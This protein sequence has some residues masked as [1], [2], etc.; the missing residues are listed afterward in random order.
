VRKSR[1]RLSAWLACVVVGGAVVL[2]MSYRSSPPAF[3]Q[4]DDSIVTNPNVFLPRARVDDDVLSSLRRARAAEI[5]AAALQRAGEEEAAMD[6]WRDAFGR[7]EHLRRDHLRPDLGHNEE[8]LV[9]ADWADAS[10]AVQAEVFAESWQPLADYINS[11]LRTG[12]WPRTFR[13]RLAQRQR[14]PGAEMLELAL[15][16][17]DEDALR[18][19][20]RFYQFSDSGRRAL[21]LLAQRSLERGDAIMA[22]RWLEELRGAWPEH[23]ERTPSLHVL[24]VR[25]CRDADMDYRLGRMLRQLE[26]RGL[27]G[28]VDV[29]GRE[30][31]SGE[32]VEQ[33]ARQE[34]PHAR[35]ELQAGGWR[36][37]QGRFDRNG[38][39]P[40]VTRIGAMVDLNPG[41]DEVAGR[42]ITD[43]VSSVD[44]QR[45]PWAR[46]TRT[47]T[48]M[49]FPVT[50]ESGVYVP[51]LDTTDPTANKLYWFRHGREVNPLQLEIPRHRRYSKRESDSRHGGGWFHHTETPRD[52]FSVHG[53]SIGTL[54]YELDGREADALFAVVGPG[55]PSAERPSDPSGNQIQG[56]NL[57]DDASV[58]MTLPNERVES[59]EEYNSFLRHVVF[60]GAPL[61]RGNRLY[62]AGVMTE[63]NSF[64]TWLFCFDVTPK[65]DS[66]AGG[67]KLMWRAH[68]GSNSFPQ[69][70]RGWGRVTN[71]EPPEVSSPA[72]SGGMVFVTSHAGFTAG[73]EAESGEVAW[74]SRYGR[75]DRQLGWFNNAPVV[76]AGLVV[77]APYD[78]DLSLVLDTV[79]GT[80]WMEY[81]IRRMGFSGE[82]EHVLGAVDG[83]LI[84]Q[85]RTRLHCIG[86]PRFRPG[87]V[88]HTDYGDLVYQSTEFSSPPG[89][90]GVI[91]G[92]RILIPY[93]SSI[94]IYDVRTGKLLSTARLDGLHVD[95]LP[96][97]LTVFSRGPAYEDEFGQTRYGPVTVTD[98]ETGNQYNVEHLRNGETFTFPGTDR[99]AVVEKE[100]FLVHTTARWMH[101]FKVDDSKD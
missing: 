25:A 90:R 35:R 74:V 1:S 29:G 8:L 19:C 18:R 40:P 100:T 17:D 44:A 2:A 97:T 101:M 80:L 69:Q 22:V 91:A 27:S 96:A 67:G 6:R 49:I 68:L 82:Y 75:T 37:L 95:N 78:H 3:A 65:G 24:Y 55:A 15:R 81:P 26:R 28:T 7:Y 87:G 23:F 51:K 36:T 38:V 30:Y 16:N 63:R 47:P 88:R 89:G 61:I 73:V 56:W 58:L 54:R 21:E 98:P 48:P 4:S 83:H 86:L 50:H 60:R 57:S 64:E 39:A 77:T 43:K 45:D 71:V 66:A 70:G 9:R 52:T 20:A 84:I 13:D 93:E 46:Q 34:A 92:D 94:A 99:T 79:R 14:V 72:E 33:I 5:E 85:G 76:A 31:D 12:P 11:R 53:S 32:L 59:T 42:Q 62:I 10:G 41:V